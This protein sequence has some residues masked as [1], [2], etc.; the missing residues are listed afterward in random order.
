MRAKREQINK[1]FA[2]TL[3]NVP[4]SVSM[5]NNG[6]GATTIVSIDIS[7]PTNRPNG[8]YQQQFAERENIH[9]TI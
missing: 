2:E 4:I 8:S 9:R 6:S 7:I 3:A 1:E 5:K